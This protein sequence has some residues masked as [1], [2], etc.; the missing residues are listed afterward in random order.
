MSLIQQPL[1]SLHSIYVSRLTRFMIETAG[2]H[3]KRAVL[4]VDHLKPPRVGRVGELTL[5]LCAHECACVCRGLGPVQDHGEGTQAGS[6]Q[7]CTVQWRLHSAE[8][9]ALSEKILEQT[10]R[11]KG[12]RFEKPC[13]GLS[14]GGRLHTEA[15]GTGPGA[16]S[17]PLTLSS[18]T[19]PNAHHSRQLSGP[20]P[21]PS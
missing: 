15:G 8:E 1:S 20:W 18:G 21:P 6:L 2:T 12:W 9:A 14:E 3:R 19:F 4:L 5:T 17:R 7:G 11:A 13:L 16:R 10:A